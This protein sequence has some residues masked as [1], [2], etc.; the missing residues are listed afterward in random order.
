MDIENNDSSAEKGMFLISKLIVN[1][2]CKT[3]NP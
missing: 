2:M 3:K 1:F